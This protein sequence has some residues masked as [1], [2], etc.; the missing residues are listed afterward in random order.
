MYR[1]KKY[2]DYKDF[3]DKNLDSFINNFYESRK[4]VTDITDEE[5]YFYITNLKHEIRLKE[6]F[7]Y[8]KNL[9]RLAMLLVK[10]E[11]IEEPIKQLE[12]LACYC[13]AHLTYTNQGNM[14]K[15]YKALKTKE[16]KTILDCIKAVVLTFEKDIKHDEVRCKRAFKKISTE[17]RIKNKK[18]AYVYFKGT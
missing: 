9:M 14:N 6:I 5:E 3:V 16:K 11:N 17:R 10:A 18:I 1:T 13:R 7:N 15:L 2:R 8:R 12:S 4:V